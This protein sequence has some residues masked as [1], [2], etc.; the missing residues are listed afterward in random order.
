MS[1]PET[2]M[3]RTILLDSFARIQDQVRSVLDGLGDQDARWRPDPEANPI[4]WLVWHLSRVTD[5]HIAAL[6]DVEQVWP[7]QGFADRFALPYPAEAIGY[8]QSSDDVGR[9]RAEPTALLEYHRATQQLVRE[10][11]GNLELAELE[12]VVDDAWDPPVT[13]AV[14]LISVLGEA[15]AH[16]G[17]AQYVRGMLSR[18][19]GR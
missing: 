13:A 17:Q 1:T 6:A 5:D 18:V 2:T 19:S 14:R 12:R 7:S 16:I 8:G 9:F 3:L 10:Y 11:L 4:G 15:I